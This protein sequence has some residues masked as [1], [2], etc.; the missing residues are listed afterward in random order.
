MCLQGE[1][2]MTTGNC[3]Y[4]GAYKVECVYLPAKVV[5]LDALEGMVV[6]HKCEGDFLVRQEENI[7][8]ER[9]GFES[10][11][12][13]KTFNYLSGSYRYFCG[14]CNPGDPREI[15]EDG[16]CKCGWSTIYFNEVGL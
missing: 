15:K 4:C 3:E 5:D 1:S 8:I 13:I 6:C 10:R 7:Q 9:A 14:E 2:I 11:R 12:G 16:H